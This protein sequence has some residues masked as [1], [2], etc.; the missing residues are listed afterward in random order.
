VRRDTRV[1]SDI[2]RLM[3]RRT[4]RGDRR[5][6]PLPNNWSSCCLRSVSD[7]ASD[8]DDDEE[9]EEVGDTGLSSQLS[10]GPGIGFV[11]CSSAWIR[12]VS[13]AMTDAASPPTT[14]WFRSLLLKETLPEPLAVKLMLLSGG[15]VCVCECQSITGSAERENK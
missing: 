15:L 3:A 4:T 11:C 5:D 14:S 2:I 7:I 10:D 1:S 8:D 12:C 6:D 9:D 13:E